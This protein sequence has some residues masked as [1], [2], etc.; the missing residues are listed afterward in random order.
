MVG[1]RL[2]A[3]LLVAAYLSILAATEATGGAWPQDETD[4]E[5]VY[6]TA[7]DTPLGP[8]AT[9]V[10]VDADGGLVSVGTELPSELSASGEMVW[11]MTLTEEC[12]PDPSKPN[13]TV[14]M[15]IYAPLDL[16]FP[17]VP[18]NPFVFQSLFWNPMGHSPL[19]V[20]SVPHFDFHFYMTA[21][22]TVAS[23]MPGP[24]MGLHPEAFSA[25]TMPIPE[26][27]WPG[28]AAAQSSAGPPAMYLNMG[29]VVP[30]MG[31]HLIDV[32]APEFGFM[33]NGGAPSGFNYSWIYGTYNGSITYFEPMLAFDWLLDE[34]SFCQPIPGQPA[35]Y[36]TP[37]LYPTTYCILTD[38]DEGML[39]VELRDFVQSDG[40]CAEASNNVFAEASYMTMPPGTAPL[41]VEC[42]YDV[43]ATGN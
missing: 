19:G 18:G 33:M 31:N 1:P 12:Q 3:T 9:Y 35:G 28:S 41:P 26:Q 42:G 6:G 23:I 32:A 40:G 37:G 20:Y 14:C 2:T 8:I 4:S 30:F 21:P 22:E 34:P 24:C 39:R 29:A 10:R 15:T 38:T 13:A 7:V 36:S 11:N 25:A 43:A 5:T 27:C 17:T 16:A